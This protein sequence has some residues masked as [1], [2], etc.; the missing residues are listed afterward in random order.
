MDFELKVNLDEISK[1]LGQKRDTIEG[2]V[3]SEVANLSVSTHAFVVQYSQEKLKGFQRQ[4]F[5]GKDNG[6]VRWSKI[7]EGM[8]VVEIDES[9]KWIE[10][11]RDRTFMGDWLLKPG[12]PGVKTAKDG[13]QYRVIPMGQARGV[14]GKKDNKDP[15]LQTMIKGALKRNSIRLDRIEKGIDGKPKLGVLHKLDI[16][17][18]HR[19]DD[20]DKFFSKPRTP[21]MAKQ[22]GLPA[23]NGHFFLSNAVV[24]QREIENGGKSKVSKEVVTF[25]VISSKHKA[26]N[27]WMYPKVEAL[28]SIPEAFK[29]AES[30][31]D[32]IVKSMEV[33]FNKTGESE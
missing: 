14:G 2:R 23:H 33:E 31:W 29:Y 12:D 16:K 21:A 1:Q 11:G 17:I 5:F 13:S 30:E 18:A 8:W 32:R 4:M 25:R 3:E 24:V 22:L 7:G 15:F 9:V 19:T 10:E 20:H 27:R 28:N 26:E 6:N